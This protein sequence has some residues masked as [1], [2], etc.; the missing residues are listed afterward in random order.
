LRSNVALPTWGYADG[1]APQIQV[2]QEGDTVGTDRDWEKW[3]ATDPYFGVY[4]RERFRTET[5]TR[6]ARDEFFESGDQHIE[7][8]LRALRRTFDATF[9]PKSALDFGSGV[10]RLV[11]PLAKRTERVTGVDVSA[12]MIAE[13]KRNCSKAQVS[14]VTFVESDDVL[15]RVH[16]SYDL[17]HSYIVLQHIAWRRGRTILQALADRVAPG[18]CLAVQFLIG[19]ESPA[20]IRGLVHLRYIFPPANWLRNVLRGRPIFEPAMQL[21]VY[22]LKVIKRDL[23]DRGFTLTHEKD[24]WEGTRSVMLYARRRPT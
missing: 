15:S 23:E 12:S 4:S 6:E 18:G 20:I 2:N 22:D 1:R 10:G 3:G 8:V 24:P 9:N 21:H 7:N 11:I 13:A 5:M 14:N 17:V 19:H 16:D